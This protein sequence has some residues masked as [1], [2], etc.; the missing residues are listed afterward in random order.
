MEKTCWRGDTTSPCCIW[1]GTTQHLSPH[2]RVYG[3][4]TQGNTTPEMLP[5][6]LY[7]WF[8]PLGSEAHLDFLYVSDRVI[9]P[10]SCMAVFLF[11]C[12][13]P[14]GRH[15]LFHFCMFLKALNASPSS[16]AKNDFV[17]FLSPSDIPVAPSFPSFYYQEGISFFFFF[18]CSVLKYVINSNLS[19]RIS[20]QC[21]WILNLWIRHPFRSVCRNDVCSNLLKGIGWSR[22]HQAII[23]IGKNISDMPQWLIKYHAEMHKNQCHWFLMTA[24]ISRKK[25]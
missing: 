13:S 20:M 16:I 15:L 1:A 12:I 2:L 10:Q 25:N 11:K 22:L 18:F 7:S 14:L 5:K 4:Y 6:L 19:F 9:I 21:F 23:S 3:I 24:K 17:S 8:C